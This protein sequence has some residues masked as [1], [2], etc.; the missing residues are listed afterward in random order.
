MGYSLQ[1]AQTAQSGA[2]ASTS[3]PFVNNAEIVFG[4]DNDV[5]SDSGVGASDA[6][7]D[8]S[9]SSGTDLNS[10]ASAAGASGSSALIWVSVAGTVIALLLAFKGKIAV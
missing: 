8:P 6:D 2:T 9:T 4:T 3:V 5:G 1:V 7:A 10:A